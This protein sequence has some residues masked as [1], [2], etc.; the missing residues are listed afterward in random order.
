MVLG[1][2]AN[3]VGAWFATVFAFWK[4]HYFVWGA[5]FALGLGVVLLV[6][7]VF[8]ALARMEEIAAVA[9][10]R[11]PRRLLQIA[12]PLAPEARSDRKSRS[13][14]RPIASRRKCSRRRSMR[15]RR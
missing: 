5:A 15:S 9:F 8:I 13:I 4:W 2:S 6:P 10:G 7:L 14:F 3:A 1:T 11:K 12:P